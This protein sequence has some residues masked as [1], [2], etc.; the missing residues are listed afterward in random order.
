[1]AMD[2]VATAQQPAPNGDGRDVTELVLQDLR[3]RSAAGTLKYGQP[4]RTHN[5]RNAMIDAYQEALDLTVYL[6][7]RIG[8][9]GDGAAERLPEIEVTD[10]ITVRPVQTMGG[11]HMVVAAAKV[12]TTGADAM[13]F[14]HA[15]HA[16]ANAGLI[17]YLMAHRH[18][19]P[20]EHA[21]MTFF[22]HA[23]IF[24][25]REWHRHR[26]GFSYNEESARY[27]Q[28]RPVF[29]VPPPDRK[30]VPAPDHTSARPRFQ[31]GTPDQLNDLRASLVAS[32]QAAYGTYDALI[33][34]GFAKEVARACLPVGVY[35]SCWVTTN[36]RAL[37][38]FLSLR[39]HEPAATFVSYPQAEIEQ[40][41]RVAEGILAEGWP[42]TY[43]AFVKNGRVGP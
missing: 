19:T 21:A 20:F 4:L 30:I 6:R 33:R 24:V 39:V 27:K 14:A 37:M 38:H 22:V 5:G 18:G 41:A 31:A 11:D 16:D 35:S 2:S 9:T 10:Q 28:L 7:Q 40:A 43:A 12:S 13:G 42:L 15:E 17:N 26:I 36:P 1:M 34:R 3:E 32:Y 23:P 25:W 29:W 8:E